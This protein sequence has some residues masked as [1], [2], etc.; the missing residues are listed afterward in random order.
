MCENELKSPNTLSNH[1]TTA[2]TTTPF[3]MDLIVPCIGINRLISHNKTPTTISTITTCI[4]GTAASLP[5]KTAH[6][7][8]IAQEIY[9]RGN[10]RAIHRRA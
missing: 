5:A 4:S 2:I 9:N 1:K 7:A 8:R 10:V 6:P 3:K